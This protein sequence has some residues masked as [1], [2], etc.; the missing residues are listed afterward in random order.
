MLPPSATG[1]FSRR[2]PVLRASLPLA[3]A[4]EPMRQAP[5]PPHATRRAARRLL[6]LC[7]AYFRE[8]ICTLPLPAMR[9]RSV[10]E[11][12]EGRHRN[13]EI[14]VTGGCASSAA[15]LSVGTRAYASS[16]APPQPRAAQHEG[17]CTCSSLISERVF[18]LSPS[19]PCGGDRFLRCGKADSET[20]RSRLQ[21][22]WVFP[23]NRGGRST[24]FTTK[25]GSTKLAT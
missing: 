18:T 14:S 8:G 11:V 12:R 4:R 3:L 7:V 2:E 25:E 23:R 22:H 16:A 24:L 13:P 20:P 9:W 17:C 21:F 1:L 10:F 15:P 6:R 5:P 19:R